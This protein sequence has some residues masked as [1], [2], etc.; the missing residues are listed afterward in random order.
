[1]NKY[2]VNAKGEAGQCRAS[3]ACPFGD[4]DHHFSTAQD[5]RKAY[6][7]VMKADGSWESV[8][9]KPLLTRTP[10]GRILDSAELEEMQEELPHLMARLQSE[11]S[12][13]DL[14][15]NLE[16]AARGWDEAP[17]GQP[18]REAG[19]AFHQA[20]RQAE[21]TLPNYTSPVVPSKF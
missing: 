16:H 4:A 8:S 5:A 14:A 19:L 9:K 17:M 3:K 13:Q 1:M 20:F 2:H 18:K 6:E 10:E 12:Y 7:L 21:D 11:S 15:A